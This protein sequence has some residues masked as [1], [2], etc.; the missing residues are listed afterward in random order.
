MRN[1]IWLARHAKSAMYLKNRRNSERRRNE[2]GEVP[3]G[4]PAPAERWSFKDK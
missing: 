1:G 4:L 2:N 3:A